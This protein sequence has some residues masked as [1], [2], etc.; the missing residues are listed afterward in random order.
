MSVPVL[1]ESIATSGSTTPTA[2]PTSTLA[3]RN[4][5]VVA[6][7]EQLNQLHPAMT[8]SKPKLSTIEFI[9]DWFLKNIPTTAEAVTTVIVKPIVGKL[10]QAGGDALVG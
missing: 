8:T 3:T 1:P 10:A 7:V 9:R 4:I 5:E 2:E 6:A